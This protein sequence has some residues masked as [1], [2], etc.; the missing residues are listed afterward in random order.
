MEE[1]CSSETSVDFQRTIRHV[2]QNIE[3]FITTAV[4]TSNSAW[5]EMVCHW[6]LVF[7]FMHISIWYVLYITEPIAFRKSGL[8]QWFQG[9]KTPFRVQRQGLIYNLPTGSFVDNVS[10]AWKVYELRPFNWLYI[11]YLLKISSPQ[12]GSYWSNSPTS[13]RNSAAV[14]IECTTVNDCARKSV[15]GTF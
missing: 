3:L 4:R 7:S 11:A 13:F 8:A 5:Y 15:D 9:R 12:Y 10:W 6:H 2:F 14:R 1:T